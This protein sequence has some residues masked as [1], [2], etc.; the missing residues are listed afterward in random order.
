MAKADTTPSS[1]T[2]RK[3]TAA[4]TEPARY[5]EPAQGDESCQMAMSDWCS[6]RATTPETSAVFR[7]YCV[8]ARA[9]TGTIRSMAEKRAPHSPP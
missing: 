2:T 7:T 8:N 9:A 1:R 3:T 4:A 5:A 6:F